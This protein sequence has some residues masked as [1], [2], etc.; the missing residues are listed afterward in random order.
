MTPRLATSVYVNALV[1]RVNAAGGMAAVL[2]KGDETAGALLLATL[3]KGRNMGLWERALGSDGAYRWTQISIQDIENEQEISEILMRR[4]R[5]DP[6]LWVV[7][8]DIAD[9]ARFAAD[10]DGER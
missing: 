10:L 2:S 6:D 7:E 8:L 4:R 5:F 1:R 3:E 9:A